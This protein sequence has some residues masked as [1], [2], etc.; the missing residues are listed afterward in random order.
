MAN[1][2]ALSSL[3]KKNAKDVTFAWL[4]V[5]PKLLTWQKK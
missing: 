5:L 1:F 4:R 3:T 2:E